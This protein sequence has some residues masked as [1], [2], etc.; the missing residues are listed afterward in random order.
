MNP[1][2]EGIN[3]KYYIGFILLIFTP[4][5][6]LHFIIKSDIRKGTMF[7][8][9]ELPL[10]IWIIIILWSAAVITFLWQREK[11]KELKKEN[12]RLKNNSRNK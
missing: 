5:V 7:D 4:P 3:F 6:A 2:N 1:E 8:S 10:S 12:E 11:I 9:D